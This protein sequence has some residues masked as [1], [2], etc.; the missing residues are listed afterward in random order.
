MFL[1]P[2]CRRRHGVEPMQW[3]GTHILPVLAHEH[4]RD[5]RPPLR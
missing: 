5:G 2:T 4:D 3:M 1:P